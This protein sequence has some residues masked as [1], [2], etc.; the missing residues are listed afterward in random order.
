MVSIKNL[1]IG[2]FSFLLISAILI[3][4]ALK[5]S[6]FFIE[7][8]HV[9]CNE[10]LKT[11][12]HESDFECQL[13]KFHHTHQINFTPEEVTFNIITLPSVQ[14]FNY[15]NFLSEYQALHFSL[16]GPPTV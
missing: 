3:P 15:Y 14:N 16:R 12:F 5:F 7:D 13:F 1:L 11:H 2:F 9:E 8:G 10:H 6:H 4:S